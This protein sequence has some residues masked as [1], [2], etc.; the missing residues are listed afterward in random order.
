MKMVQLLTGAAAIALVAGAASAQTVGVD[1]ANQFDAAGNVGDFEAAGTILASEMS[2]PDAGLSGELMVAVD[3][4]AGGGVFQTVGASDQVDFTI[5]VT[6]FE[7][8]R[9]VTSGDVGSVAGGALGDCA[10]AIQAGGANGGNTVTF[11]S[12]GQINQCADNDLLFE[13]PV[14]LT[15][16]NANF[17]WEFSLVGPD[18]SLAS[19]TYDANGATPAVDEPLVTQEAAF[20]ITIADG[21]NPAELDAPAYILFGGNTSDQF[22]SVSLTDNGVDDD[23]AGTDITFAEVGNDSHQLVI[24]FAN[25]SGIASVELS[26]ADDVIGG[27]T[28]TC[29]PSGN[30][31][32]IALDDSEVAAL[33]A[34]AGEVFVVSANN[35]GTP[36]AAQDLS[37]EIVLNAAAG[38]STTPI[39]GKTGDLD[40]IGRDDGVSSRTPLGSNPGIT[41]AGGNSSVNSGNNFPWTNLRSSGGTQSN[42]RITGM[43][44][45]L[46]QDSDECVRV[47][48]SNTNGAL[49]GAASACLDAGDVTVTADGAAANTW[50]ATF[51]STAIANA[52]GITTE[53]LNGDVSFEVITHDGAPGGDGEI[54]RLLIKNGIVTGTGF[55]G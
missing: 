38:Y 46:N 47:T 50:S 39:T 42:F 43:R 45:D 21:A 44:T 28:T 4:S 54:D 9:V 55:D 29:V 35:A 16:N 19:D 11:R 53:A 18:T 33:I 1:S 49:P 14:N 23:L 13:L 12:S 27:D 41:V 32:T 31:C 17:S 5:T 52:L 15:A 10:F 25:A 36:I 48:V 8:N 30:S 37:A 26:L 6:G 24:T 2:I 22:G 3:L 34:D 20:E 7:F 40:S 51:N